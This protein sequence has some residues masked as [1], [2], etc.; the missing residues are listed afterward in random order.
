MVAA[1]HLSAERAGLQKEEIEELVNVIRR[2]DLPT[3]L[4]ERTVANP[5]PGKGLC[6]QEVRERKNPFRRDPETGE[7]H[8]GRKYHA[9]RSRIRAESNR[10]H[11]NVT[12]KEA[13]IAL[14]MVPHLGPVRLRRLLDIFDSPERVLSAKRNELQGVDGLN[15]ALI[16]SL[17]SWES[18]V[19][20]P[21]ELARIHEFGATVLTLEDA[22]YPTLLREIHDPP[23]VLYV[24]G[25]LEAARSSRDRGGRLQADFPLRIGVR[26]KDLLP[27]R[28]R[29]SH[30]G[31]RFG[32]RHRHRVPP[33]SA[34]RKGPDHRRFGNGTASSVSGRKSSPGRK[35]R[36][37]PV[38][39]SPSSRWRQNRIGKHSRCGI[40]LSAAGDSGCWSSR[41]GINSGALISASQAAD[42]GRNLYAIPGPIDRPTSHGTNR[43]DSAGR[44]ACHER[45]RYP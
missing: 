20:L 38:R 35:N 24:W 43:S 39:W 41:P 19:D 13:F 36:R 7:R 22:D 27:D 23:T 9:R 11:A 10:P 14:N 17:V 1:A 4:P 31:Q 45:R 8:S 29:W 28:L 15:Q 32:P 16:D 12:R 30:G 34:G 5:D 26:K 44:K 6:R 3:K 25:K 40:E 37:P 21:Q 18:V 33:R 2:L 42:Q